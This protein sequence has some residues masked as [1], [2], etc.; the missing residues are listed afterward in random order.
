MLEGVDMRSIM[1]AAACVLMASPALAFDDSVMS[2]DFGNTLISKGNNGGPEAHIY[3]NADHSF[4]GKVLSP[5]IALKGTWSVQ[6]EQ[7]CMHY[8][9]A[10]FGVKNPA[11]V[12]ITG[13]HQVGDI[14]TDGKHQISLV[15][16]IQ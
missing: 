12:T 6:G 15:A 2:A 1:L 9:P 10:P 16:G 14:W 3:Y 8:T 5:A 11:C 7:F 4:T 13:P